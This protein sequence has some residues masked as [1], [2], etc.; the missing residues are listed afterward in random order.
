M[1]QTP[2]T[3]ADA[4]TGKLGTLVISQELTSAGVGRGYS[5]DN[6][7]WSLDGGTGAYADYK[8]GGRFAA[9]GL[10][11]RKLLFREEGYVSKG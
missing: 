7:T 10:P 1:R 8:G 11:N 3:G 5:N 4:M 2:I 9:V 6:G